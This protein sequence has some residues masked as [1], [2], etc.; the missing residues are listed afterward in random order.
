M[1][2]SGNSKKQSSF[3]W[4]L[5]IFCLG[6][7]GYVIWKQWLFMVGGLMAFTLLFVLEE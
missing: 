7:I 6:C 1:K 2:K 3:I 4:G 5:L